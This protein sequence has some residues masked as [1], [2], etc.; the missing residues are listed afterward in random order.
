MGAGTEP[1]PAVVPPI[2][3]AMV[4]IRRAGRVVR[5]IGGAR[6]EPVHAT[7]TCAVHGIRRAAIR[8]GVIGRRSLGSRTETVFA[9][10]AVA[11]RARRAAGLFRII[12]GRTLRVAAE[13]A[14]AAGAGA[15][16]GIGIAGIGRSVC[17]VV[18]RRVPLHAS[19]EV[20]HDQRVR[21]RRGHEKRLLIRFCNGGHRQAAESPQQENH[22]KPCLH[23][24]SY[25][26]VVDAP[27]QDAYPIP[28]NTCTEL[29]YF[30]F[31]PVTSAWYRFSDAFSA[32]KPG[33]DTDFGPSVVS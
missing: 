31:S 6:T 20:Q 3:I 32:E 26:Y 5:V 25:S 14:A 4:V 24:A 28:T 29:L 11:S 2:A 12:R 33:S 8:S 15:V 30:V 9:I 21:R 17:Q 27:P 1:V 19:R 23:E 7:G 16:C 10:G 13:S 18:P 22:Q